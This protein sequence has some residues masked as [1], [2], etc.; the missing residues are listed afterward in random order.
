MRRSLRCLASGA[1]VLAFVVATSIG[2]DSTEPAQVGGQEKLVAVIGDSYMAGIGVTQA[3][4]GMA[5]KLAEDLNMKLA[6]FAVG[7]T[8]YITGGISGTQTFAVQ[9]DSALATGADLYIVEGALNDWVT[10]YQRQTDDLDGFKRAVRTLYEELAAGAGGADVVVVGP[11]WPD[12]NPDAGILAIRDILKEQ[13][14]DA[15]LTFIDPLAEEWVTPQN[16]ADYMGPD[17]IHPNETGHAYI[18]QRIADAID[19]TG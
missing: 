9:A 1:S 13:A 16:A 6:N 11:I 10:I 14:R 17:L 2:C 3:D 5:V 15:G 8:G 18:A 7:G 12:G 19:G 4:Q